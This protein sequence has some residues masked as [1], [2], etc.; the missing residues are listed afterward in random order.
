MC[1]Y[2]TE[3]AVDEL[4]A[5]ELRDR[6]G[7]GGGFMQVRSRTWSGCVWWAVTSRGRKRLH[8]SYCWL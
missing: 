7:S 2:G 5:V 6:D 1:N 4:R 3:D 8:V